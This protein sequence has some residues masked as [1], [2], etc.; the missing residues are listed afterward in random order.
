MNVP[1]DWA[2][3]TGAG[4]GIGAALAREL[5][6]RG[7]GVALVGRRRDRLEQVHDGIIGLSPALVVHA[8]IARQED[9][10]DLTQSV[11]KG[12]AEHGGRLKY[13]IHNAGVGSPSPDFMGVEPEALAHA[14]AVNVTAPLALSQR[15]M[16]DLIASAPARILFVGA[17]IADRPQPGTGIYGISKKALARL[18]DQILADFAYEQEPRLPY[19]AMF[20]P[21][22]VDTEGLRAHVDAARR[23]K[24]PHSEYL[25]AAINDGKARRPGDVASAMAKAL[26]ELSSP[27]YHGQ[28]LS[29][30]LLSGGSSSNS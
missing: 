2:L 7:I 18:F 30:S 22:M 5:A 21:G 20:Q 26:V 23:C 11:S 19:V 14:F 4:S 13:L 8:D 29:P 6:T 12:L 1:S 15:F 28:T 10:A 24:L 16:P 25:A 9:R 3:I 27:D 17:G